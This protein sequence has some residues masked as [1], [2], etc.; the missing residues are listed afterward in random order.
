MSLSALVVKKHWC[1]LLK[2]ELHLALIEAG[3]S[4]FW[5][6]PDLQ[7]SSPTTTEDESSC[8]P[9]AEC[10]DE[11]DVC[12]EPVVQLDEEDIQT[13]RALLRASCSSSEPS[14]SL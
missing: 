9:A 5:T 3:L 2:E 6:E 4:L 11:E 1:T 8:T 12:E 14:G 7:S 13:D 10:E